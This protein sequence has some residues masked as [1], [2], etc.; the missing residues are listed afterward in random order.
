MSL[1]VYATK[2][3]LVSATKQGI[4]FDGAVNVNVSVVLNNTL[5]QVFALSGEIETQMFI[6][7]QSRHSDNATLVT[8]NMSSLV[9]NMS[10]LSSAIGKFIP[11]P[12]NNTSRA[13]ACRLA[14]LAVSCRVL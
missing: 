8:G 9:C 6:D 7:L 14:R 4:T 3:P 12:R 11:R 5:K 13:S 2:P 1:F 10:L